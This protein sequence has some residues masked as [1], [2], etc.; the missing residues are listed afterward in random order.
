MP[1][2]IIKAG[3]GTLTLAGAS[4]YTGVTTGSAGT[5]KLGA[6]SGASAGPLGSTGT[7]TVLTSGATID[8]GGFGANIEPISIEGTGVGGNGA[9]VNSGGEQTNAVRFLNADRPMHPSAPAA[10]AMTS[11]V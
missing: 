11:A 7:G 3:A 9:L 2:K 10:A 5:L 4:T 6:S 1:T 8:F